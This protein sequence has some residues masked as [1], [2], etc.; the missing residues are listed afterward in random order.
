MDEPPRWMV[1]INHVSSHK[2]EKR[3]KKKSGHK[4]KQGFFPGVHSVPYQLY[5]KR[6]LY[7]LTAAKFF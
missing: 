7:L 2:T 4:T 6:T 1:A 3:D 5:L